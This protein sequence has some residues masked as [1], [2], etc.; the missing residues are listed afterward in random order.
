EYSEAA[1]SEALRRACDMYCD[2]T[3][4]NQLIDTGMRQ[5]WSWAAS[6]RQYVKLY[7][8]TVARKNQ[9]IRV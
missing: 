7:E 9:A 6:A 8:A 2:K 4:W 1:F 3:R 5:D